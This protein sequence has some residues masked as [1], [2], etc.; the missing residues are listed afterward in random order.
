MIAERYYTVRADTLLR[1]YRVGGLVA[2][3][4]RHIGGGPLQNL[5][6]FHARFVGAGD[7]S[8]RVALCISDSLHPSATLGLL[9]P[10]Q[11]VRVGPLG[12][13]TRVCHRIDIV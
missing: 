8:K 4:K 7:Q 10:P 3:D 6:A 1:T 2:Q 13:F 11:N 9:S 5:R 12:L